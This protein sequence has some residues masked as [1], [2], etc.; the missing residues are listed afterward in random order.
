MSDTATK[1]RRKR[2]DGGDFKKRS[3]V[4]GTMTFG[5]KTMAKKLGVSY[6]TVFRKRKAKEISFFRVGHRILYNDECLREFL[7]KSREAA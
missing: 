2:R 1:T 3:I 5:E 7:A 6:M 4:D